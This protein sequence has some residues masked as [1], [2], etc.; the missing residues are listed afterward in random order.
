MRCGVLMVMTSVKISSDRE[1]ATAGAGCT[2]RD[3]AYTLAKDNLQLYSTVEIGNLTVGAMA[4]SHTKNR[5]LPDEYGILSS[6]VCGVT[7]VDGLGRVHAIERGGTHVDGLAADGLP[8]MIM[9]TSHGSWYR[10]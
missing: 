4:C 9:R 6:Y 7:M 5:H 8:E 3:L 1:Y 10:V 2:L